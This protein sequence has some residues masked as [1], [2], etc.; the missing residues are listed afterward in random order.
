[1]P[2]PDAASFWRPSLP[3]LPE[4]PPSRMARTQDG[5]LVIRMP[6]VTADCGRRPVYLGR[7]LAEITILRASDCHPRASTREEAERLTP[8]EKQLDLTSFQHESG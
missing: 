4:H 1:M 8:A 5:F 7:V 2:P 3:L 6:I